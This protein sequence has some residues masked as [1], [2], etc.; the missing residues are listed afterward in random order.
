MIWPAWVTSA[1]KNSFPFM[2]CNRFAM[3]HLPKFGFL[4][5]VLVTLI[6]AGGCI[7]QQPNEVVVYSA[8]DR[9][10]SEPILNDLGA[11][12]ELEI[13]TK[14]DQESNKTVGL[15]T[16]IIQSS[17]IPQCDLFWNNEILHT[18]RL[19]KLGLLESYSSTQAPFYPSN[20]VSS[21]NQWH[22][23]AARARVLLVN[24]EL[25]PN[26]DERPDSIFDLADKKWKGRCAMARPLFGTTMTHAA[27]LF[28]ELGPEKAKSLLSQIAENTS[29]EGGNKQVAIKVARGEFAFGITDTDDA[30][31]ELEQ[32]NP[33]AIIF[34]DQA[35][36]Q[37]GTLLIPNTLSIIKGG[38]NPERAKR[39]VDRLLRSD[40]ETRLAEGA[41]SQIPLR[42]DATTIARVEAETKVKV[43]KAD[44]EAAAESW[45]QATEFLSKTFPAGGK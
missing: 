4:L 5:I 23:F 41:S 12:L 27:V 40:I 43:M 25:L 42:T 34:P 9:E 21:R 35:V 33:V 7:Q 44:F 14:F 37:M 18:I 10:F 38:P 19:Q 20:F 22:G 39:L 24:T 15:V 3:L 45:A 29:I 17:K 8:L 2:N 16:S 30:I 1:L 6:A 26:P 31:I 13:L 32:A 36:D 11:E 28:S